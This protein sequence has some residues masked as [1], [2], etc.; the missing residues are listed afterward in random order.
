MGSVSWPDLCIPWDPGR[1]EASVITVQLTNLRLRCMKAH[2]GGI[3]LGWGGTAKP[4]PHS[5]SRS[6]LSLIV[7]AGVAALANRTFCGDR[8]VLYSAVQYDSYEQHSC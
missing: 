8:N 4:S 1:S 3:T 5:F 2:D 6:L 7:A